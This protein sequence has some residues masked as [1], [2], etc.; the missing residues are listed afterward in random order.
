MLKGIIAVGLFGLVLSGCA[1]V[2]MQNLE[3]SN[4]AKAFK[5]PS[6]GKAGLYV[7]RASIMGTALKKDVWVNGECLGETAP[8]VFFYKEVEGNTSHTITTESEFGNRHLQ[9][10]VRAGENY[11]VR[12]SMRPGVFVGGAYLTNVDSAKGMA[13]V[14]KLD[15]AQTGKCSKPL[16]LQK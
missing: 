10:A 11:F 2:P 9:L 13:D 3:M 14:A 15:M 1:S 8:K 5:K 6:E 16:K 7:Y 4:Q 12:Q